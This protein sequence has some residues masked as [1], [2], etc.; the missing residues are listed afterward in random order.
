RG[1]HDGQM[2]R[3]FNNNGATMLPAKVTEDIKSG[4]V[5]MKEGAW[6]TPNEEGV[7]T[8]GCANAVTSDISA[9]CGATTYNT[10]FVQV[11]PVNT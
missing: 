11:R 7:D 8:E 9:P 5:S 2:V 10:N 1:I 3:V 6:F 4:A